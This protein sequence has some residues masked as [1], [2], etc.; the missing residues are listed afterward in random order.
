[1]SDDLRSTIEAAVSAPEVSHEAPVQAESPPAVEAPAPV[2]AESAPVDTS[3]PAGAQ[4]DTSEIKG[5]ESNPPSI[6]EVAGAE[7]KSVENPAETSEEKAARNRVDR[8]P[9]SWKGESKKVWE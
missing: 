9:Q 8:A 4:S 1:M 5:G 3:A 6:E 2:S 7:S